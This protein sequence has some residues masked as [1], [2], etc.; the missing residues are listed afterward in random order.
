MPRLALTT[1]HAT[2]TNEV[3]ALLGSMGIDAEVQ[4]IAGG[5]AELLVDDRDVAR[6]ERLLAEEYDEER[7]Q[8]PV[9]TRKP[10]RTEPE[11]FKI[12]VLVYLFLLEGLNFFRLYQQ[13]PRPQRADFLRNGALTWEKIDQ[14]EVWRFA[15]AVFVH[16]DFVH[17]AANLLTLTLIGPLVTRAFG[18]FRFLTIFLLS[19][20]GGNIVS[21]V[22]SPSGALKAGASGGV[23]GILGA[24]AGHAI[25]NRHQSRYRAWQMVAG[26]IGAYALLIGAGP[27]SDHL[28][29]AGGLAAGWALGW[30][31]APRSKEPVAV[32]SG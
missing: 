2:R 15:T 27:R 3:I 6:V 30:L 8:T 9:P 31:L 11:P 13:S 26:V 22:L 21:H 32:T 29:H 17:L 23:A 12:Q 25:A 14:G 24:C 7:L 28:A 20:V 10:V 4:S 1:L 16:F 18:G 5:Q 19:G